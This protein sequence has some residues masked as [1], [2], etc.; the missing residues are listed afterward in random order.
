MGGSLEEG[1]TPLLGE[2]VRPSIGQ[3]RCGVLVITAIVDVMSTL[4]TLLRP[5]GFNFSEFFLSQVETWSP[6][7]SV[8]D[9]ATLCLARDV[10]VVVSIL[11]YRCLSDD[12]HVQAAALVGWARRVC[13]FILM[14]GIFRVC[15]LNFSAGGDVVAHCVPFV[16]FALLLSLALS[17]Q[18]HV[19]VRMQRRADQERAATSPE[20]EDDQYSSNLSFWQTVGVLKPYFWPSTGTVGEVIVK[21]TLAMSTWIC[22]MGART[23]NLLSPIFLARATNGLTAALAAHES[24]VNEVVVWN[25]II[26]ALCRFLSNAFKETQSVLYI[27]VNQAAY[28]EIA[29]RSFQ[30]LHNLSL[31]W[32]LRKKMGNVVKSLDRGTAAA[33]STMQ[34]VFL[35]LVP[36]IIEC[37]AV[38]LIF[39]M[40]FKNFRLAV[41]A[42]AML[43]LYGYVTVKVTL[44]RKDFRTETTKTDNKVH[45]RLQDSL[46]NFETI[47][48]FTAEEYEAREYSAAVTM[49]TKFTVAT[50][51]SLSVLNLAQQMIIDV[52]IAGGML[53]ATSRLLQKGG[54]LGQFVAVNAYLLQIFQPLSFL[55]AIYSMVINAIVDFRNF[56]QLLAEKSDVQ[57]APKALVLDMTPRDAACVEFKDVSFQYRKQPLLRSLKNVSFEVPW[58]TS[59]ALVGKT[60]AGKTTL[61]RILFRFYD[62]MGGQL[63]VNGQDVRSV[64]QKSLRRAIGMVPQDVVMFND[65]IA[66]NIRYGNID[67]AT[68]ADVEKAAQAAQ[69]MEFVLQ[70]P[71]QWDTAVGE[72]GLKLSGGEKQRLAIAR[73]ILK[74]PPIVVLDEATSALDSQTER[75]VQEALST[76][77]SSRT[78]IAI[79]HRLSTVRTFNQIIVLQSGEIAEKGTHDELVQKEGKYAA[80]WRQQIHQPEE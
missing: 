70:Q 25:I 29:N 6:G 41:F 3:V 79:A 9:W 20:D 11:K 8:V 51:A 4:I 22:V 48:Y 24:F 66:H 67:E 46:V 50:Q 36:T 49:Y 32:H 72:R 33:R 35:N 21:R 59:T 26:Y 34:Y 13:G 62:V 31:D 2:Q 43:I 55:G 57:D 28:I 14:F 42:G 1:H 65:T 10:V 12:Q 61:S 56:G 78:V 19:L 45:D 16:V 15:M 18:T 5:F 44:W 63:L 17:F 60:G 75:V 47:K 68:Q 73:C 74:N 58:G 71:D 27:K 54:D 40:H 69:L 53:I 37:F 30:H 80:M 38:T 7:S 77:S 39:T 76:L 23:C 52:T 64:T